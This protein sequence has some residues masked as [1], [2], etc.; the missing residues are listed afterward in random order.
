[1]GFPTDILSLRFAIYGKHTELF[2]IARDRA[3]AKE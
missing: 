2:L 1:M 3:S